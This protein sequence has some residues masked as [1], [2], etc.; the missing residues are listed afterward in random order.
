[1]AT[2]QPSQALRQLAERYAELLRIQLGTRLVSVVL[3][4][5][6]ARGDASLGSDIDML[7]VADGL[8]RGVFAR[9]DTLA[10]VDRDF[11][12]DLARAP[13]GL[14]P[15]LARLVR[16]PEEASRL[17]PLY[18]DLTED[19]V[20]LHDRDGFFASVLDRLRTSLR[21]HGARRIRRGT[22]WYWDL[23]PDFKPGDIV[24]L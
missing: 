1:M 16:T 14:E 7:I 8:P 10:A 2:S 21:A 4:G 15:R 19:A 17:I 5:S 18:L 3:F 22:T 6:V 23:K 12:H 9:K 20:I 13:A 24:E 11:E